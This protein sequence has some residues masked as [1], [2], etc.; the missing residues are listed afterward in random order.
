MCSETRRPETGT[1]KLVVVI[2]GE[3][4]AQSDEDNLMSVG[5]FKSR[6]KE[7]RN[8]GGQTHAQERISARES[9]QGQRASA[10]LGRGV[11]RGGGKREM[12]G[13]WD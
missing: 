9:M 2:T 8:A 13:S 11:K 7:V 6:T 5:K 12:Y 1:Y 3:E 4:R 10:P